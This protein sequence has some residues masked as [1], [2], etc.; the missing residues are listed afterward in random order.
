MLPRPLGQVPP[1]APSV[2]SLSSPL[3]LGTGARLA[4]RTQSRPPRLRGGHATCLC[5]P[6]GKRLTVAKGLGRGFSEVKVGI[7]RWGRSPVDRGPGAGRCLRSVLECRETSKS[8]FTMTVRHRRAASTPLRPQR[9]PV[10]PSGQRAGG[11]RLFQPRRWRPVGRRRRTEGPVL[12]GIRVSSAQG[13]VQHALVRDLMAGTS[14]HPMRG[15]LGRR[16]NRAIE[17]GNSPARGGAW[18]AGGSPT[19]QGTSPAR[20]G[21]RRDQQFYLAE[22]GFLLTFENSGKPGALITLLPAGGG[23]VSSM[24]S[25]SCEG[26]L[27]GA[28][29]LGVRVGGVVRSRSA[30]GLADSE[31]V[32]PRGG[33]TLMSSAKPSEITSRQAVALP[34]AKSC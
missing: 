15:P 18:S 20:A 16:Q 4:V 3:G 11:G 19:R 27:K 1:P 22:R 12:R 24:S 8:P 17:A 34:C 23:P 29:G 7:R 6:P 2:V 31:P 32:P 26:K 14:P 28:E 13:G 25:V 10:T 30:C 33:R 9:F 21:P 5:V